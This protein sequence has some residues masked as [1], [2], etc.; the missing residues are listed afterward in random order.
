ML[1]PARGRCA[2]RHGTGLHGK[3]R[4]RAKGGCG[5]EDSGARTIRD[6]ASVA[7]HACAAVDPDTLA[8]LIP[9]LRSS[10]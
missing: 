8:S 1:A 9:L 5:V 2:R 10:A 7:P 6:Q 3:A 4:R